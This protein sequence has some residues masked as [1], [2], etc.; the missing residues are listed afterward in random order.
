MIGRNFVAICGDI[1]NCLNE[2]ATDAI[3]PALPGNIEPIELIA[4]D[5]PSSG[6]GA[7]FNRPSIPGTAFESFRKSSG[8]S[9]VFATPNNAPL[10]PT[11]C[12]GVIESCFVSWP[13][14]SGLGV[15]FRGVLVGRP[16]NWALATAAHAKQHA[17]I[18]ILIVLCDMIPIP[19]LAQLLVNDRLQSGHLSLHLNVNLRG[20]SRSES[21]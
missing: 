17:A 15:L 19:S 13:T 16:G 12:S 6:F 8:F 20:L 3:A 5:E 11:A 10:P 14:S 21:C 7:A 2:P 4:S 18:S 1:P 9:L